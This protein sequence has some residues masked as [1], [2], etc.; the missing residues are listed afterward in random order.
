MDHC[1]L[2]TNDVECLSRDFKVVSQCM[3]LVC[4]L[5]VWLSRLDPPPTW[6]AMAD[7]VDVV[8][9]NSELAEEVRKMEN[10]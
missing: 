2:F 7:A 3:P 6:E 4:D 9:N 5:V 8:A 1:L 10:S